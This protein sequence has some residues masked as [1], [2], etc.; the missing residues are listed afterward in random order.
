MK[1]R[2]KYIS[3]ILSAAIAFN[4]AAPAVKVAMA[5]ADNTIASLS[6]TIKNGLQSYATE[7]DVRKFDMEVDITTGAGTERINE[8]V[9]Y[10]RKMPELFCIDFSNTISI[11]AEYGP[12]GSIY[13]SKIGVKYNNTPEEAA[14]LLGEV[15]AKI[16]EIVA[17]NIKP[18]MTELDKALVLH[19]YIVLNTVYDT[20]GEIPDRDSGASAYD[21]LICGNGVCEGYAQAY[22]MLLDRVGISSIMVTSYAMN[23]AWNLVNIDNEWYH[24]D[25]TWDDPVPDSKGRVNHKYFLLSDNEIKTTTET[26][27]YIH[28]KWDSRNIE[29]TSTKYD[30]A[31]WGTVGTEICVRGDKWY[32][33]SDA[34]E[35][36]T[37]IE[38]TGEVNTNVSIDDE[39]WLVWGQE[40]QWWTGKYV[41]LIISGDKVL[42]NTPTMIYQMNLDG[43]WKQ[44][45]KYINPYETNG[46]V[47]GMRLDG[48]K[49]YAVIKQKPEDEGEY[50]EVGDMQFEE[51]VSVYNTV[52][53]TI[54][55]MNDG[56]SKS[57]NVDTETIL[58]KEAIN[59][60]RGRNIQISLNLDGYSWGIRGNKITANEEE[61]VDLNLEIEEDQG[62]IPKEM[63]ASITGSHTN[64]VELN[65]QH[66]G[67]MG[68][69]ADIN[70]KLGQQFS[71]NVA[72][73]YSYNQEEAKMDKVDFMMVDANGNLE[74]DLDNAANYAVVLRSLA[75]P[76]DPVI[77]EEEKPPQAGPAPVET[78]PAVTEPAPAVT[79]TVTT[80]AETTPAVTTT[81][82][83]TT[84]AVVTTPATTTASEEI[85]APV[86]AS[87]EITGTLEVEKPAETTEA[88]TGKVEDPAEV[89]APS[90]TETPV[91]DSAKP[92][93]G[94]VN[95]DGRVDITDLSLIS[96]F[97]L[98][99]IEFSE[100]QIQLGDVTGDGFL[101]LA[102]LATMKQFLTNVIRSF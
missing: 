47:Y 8:A 99:D 85:T 2:A 69:T 101:N 37:Y 66:D 92:L 50:F 41:S 79:T 6:E 23:H 78:A 102:D 21:I 65:L 31:F 27:Q 89:T 81:A 76:E 44:P 15:N 100:N 64:V 98:K 80:T 51:R 77:G 3:G 18:E 71:N 32:Y 24:V 36:S 60:M 54:N 26:R 45:V 58:P 87:E 10:V 14:A 82:A 88:M 19:D 34:G 93:K 67:P 59:C 12:D 4:F 63:L 13:I 20:K 68:L 5:A 72:V 62:V 7:I 29:A 55:S 40:G 30:K 1:K 25:T 16:D 43:S 73:L 86:S 38:S 56:D 46:Y 74:I 90:E 61:T 84:T 75:A 48:D 35:Y 33:V 52:M 22:N 11:Q 83:E 49:L 91:P 97:N 53:E 95:G 42:Y 17:E 96:L 9:S 94:D 39:K 28:E 70:Y 57:F